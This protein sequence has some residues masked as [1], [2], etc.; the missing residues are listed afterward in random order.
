MLAPLSSSVSCHFASTLR[1]LL[2]TRVMSADNEESRRRC[3][4][5]YRKFSFLQATPLRF[6]GRNT[7]TIHPAPDP[8]QCVPAV[9]L[10][11]SSGRALPL[12]TRRVVWE[13]LELS[14]FSRW[15]R[16]SLVNAL[17]LFLL[18]ISTV[19]IIGAQ[20]QEARFALSAS[21]ARMC[22]TTL[23]A[24]AFNVSLAADG[25]VAPGASFPSGTLQLNY[26]A[27]PSVCPPKS[28]R[29]YFKDVSG[30]ARTVTTPNASGC[31]SEC[32]PD[33]SQDPG[34]TLS[35]FQVGRGG[36]GG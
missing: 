3:I 16:R 4:D 6:R 20:S 30:R 36:V 21:T 29:F 25:S 8:S 35:C 34:S 23:P 27:H 28:S 22:G 10:C 9:T 18:A 11:V 13:N 17:V 32:W 14:A 2:S 12:L 31:L 1:Y 19:V 5:D 7:L 24:V 26:A 33:S 15:R